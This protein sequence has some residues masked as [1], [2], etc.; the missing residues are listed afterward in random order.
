MIGDVA[1]RILS[2]RARLKASGFDSGP[3]VSARSTRSRMAHPKASPRAARFES[4][5]LRRKGAGRRDLATT[6]A[7]A[8]EYE[9]GPLMDIAAS[10]LT[11]CRQM[12]RFTFGSAG[13]P[14]R[15]RAVHALGGCRRLLPNRAANS[16]PPTRRRERKMQRFKSPGPAQR[17]LSTHAAVYNVFNVQR[18]MSSR[19]THRLLRS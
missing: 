19:P 18:H 7:P 6:P 14:R 2:G 8:L 4:P 9:A 12:R 16:H 10:L 5:Q 1:R 3:S 15:C 17:F 11:P 13:R